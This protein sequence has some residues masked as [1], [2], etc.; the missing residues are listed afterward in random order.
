MIYKDYIL[1]NE[2]L[3]DENFLVKQFGLLNGYLINELPNQ[4][5][6]K[7][8][9]RRFM[10]EN[11]FNSHQR[12]MI[13]NKI[14][15][16]IDLKAFTRHKQLSYISELDWSSQ[17]IK[18]VK[19][20]NSFGF[21]TTTNKHHGDS[22]KYK[23]FQENIIATPW[24]RIN[25]EPEKYLKIL[26]PALSQAVKIKFIDRFILNLEG[27][28]DDFRH[29]CLEFIG[30]VCAYYYTRNNFDVELDIFSNYKNNVFGKMKTIDVSK[31]K[32]YIKSDKSY[33]ILSKFNVN[34]YLLKEEDPL[35]EDLH[36]R[37]FWT[38]DTLINVGIG[39]TQDRRRS[40]SITLMSNKHLHEE[41]D[42]S[43]SGLD[44]DRFKVMDSFS[45]NDL[46]NI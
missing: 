15:K 25:I 24:C 36:D 23:K 44:N 38:P 1:E 20:G 16:L 46:K 45:I 6:S 4:Q 22:I 17:A 19:D 29:Q 11:N 28:Y 9:I 31:L 21:I 7:L 30:M 13:L 39:F 2:V 34:F 27:Q 14:K 42:D 18:Q 5:F 41:I 3:F 32:N 10:N 37:F 12:Y 33:D 43:Y 26:E 8:E 35:I 40:T